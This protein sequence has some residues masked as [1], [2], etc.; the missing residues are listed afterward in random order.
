MILG[1]YSEGGLPTDL[2]DKLNASFPVIVG[3]GL[4]NRTSHIVAEA[5]K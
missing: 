4:G 3:A 1:L 5:D 2:A